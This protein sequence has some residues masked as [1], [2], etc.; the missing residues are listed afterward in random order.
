MPKSGNQIRQEFIDFFKSKGHLFVPSSPV[1][2]KDD[3]TLLFTNAGMNQFKAIFLGEN[4]EGYRRAANSQ[5]CMRVSGK[6]NDLEEVGRDHYHHTFFEMLGN[7]SFGDYYKKEAI[8]WAWE[9]LTVVWKLPKDRLFVTVFESDEEAENLWKTQ[10]DIEHWRIMRFGAKSNFWEMGDTGPCGPCSEIHYDIGD[11]ADQKS[12]YNDRVRGVNG[13]NDRFREIWNLVFMQYNREK[14]GKLVELPNKHVDTG[15]GL[16]RVVSILQNTKS[17]YGTDLFSPII[18][19]L[20]KK[21]G[22]PYSPDVAGTPFRVIADHLRALVFAITDGATPSNE[23]RGYVLRRLLRR[24]AKFGRELGFHEPFLYDV[25]PVVVNMMGDAFPEIKQ[26]I[27]YVCD[28]I[29]SE[30]ERFGTT[31]EQGIEKFGQIVAALEGTGKKTIR[32]ADVFMLYDTYGFPMDLTRLI[33]EEKGL[34]VDEAGF[35]SEMSKQRE[36]ARDAAKKGDEGGFSPEGW[37]TLKQTQGTE[38]VGYDRDTAECAVCR[39]KITQGDAAGIRQ[40]LLVLDTTPL[41]AESGG[42]VGDSGTLT[43]ATGKVLSVVNT[44]KWNDM[45]VHVVQTDPPLNALELASP[46]HA[47]LLS[48]SRGPTRRNHSATHLLQAALRKILGTH[49]QQSGSRVGPDS[50]R[51]DFT[52]HKALSE[53]ELRRIEEQVNE[54]V[55]ADLPVTT[56]VKPTGEAKKEGAMALFGEKYGEN[57]RVVSMG[58]VSKELCGG[59]HVTS[60]GTIGLFHITMETSIAAGVRR[61]EAVTGM[62]SL[63]LLLQKETLIQELRRTLK[64]NEEDLVGRTQAMLTHVKDLEQKVAALSQAGAGSQVDAILAESQAVQGPCAWA[65]RNLGETDKET[66]GALCDAVS[67]A[68]KSKNLATTA[69]VLGAAIDGR[70]LF[71]ATA[72]AKAVKEGGVHC[73]ELVKA[74]AQK[75]E[76]SGGGSPTRAQAGGK[77]PAKLEEALALVRSA[78]SEKCV[79]RHIAG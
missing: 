77:N 10:T 71:F 2:P 31:L 8:S 61:I 18:A 72:G 48:D 53:G 42:Q 13:A 70:V 41:Y 69:V 33:A 24:A 23:G 12:V 29:R 63:R 67:D 78:L 4:K 28:V 22:K 54:W 43:T 6:H 36:R 40:C 68:I 73:G 58:T 11:I 59:T 62:S 76:G 3:P 38:F 52:H 21:S 14:D 79:S 5:K 64:V 50:L 44:V 66:F 17:N 55:L 56:V 19:A 7:W 75:V 35:E 20:E 30:E 47:E 25:A 60:T 9:L 16:E 74:A 49:V 51:F 57:V 39:Y 37:V 65:V 27:G 45:T 46:L 15:M 1:V 26:R 34:A 32:G